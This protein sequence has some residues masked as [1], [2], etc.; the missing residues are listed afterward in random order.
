[1]KGLSGDIWTEGD[2]FGPK[3]LWSMNQS[4][5]LQVKSVEKEK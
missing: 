1:M 5:V 3:K 2:E 4:S